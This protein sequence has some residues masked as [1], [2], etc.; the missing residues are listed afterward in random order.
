[1]RFS[2]FEQSKSGNAASSFRLGKEKKPITSRRSPEK[3]LKK[4]FPANKLTDIGE[5]HTLVGGWTTPR[6]VTTISN[7]NDEIV[8]ILKE[9]RDLQKE[10]VA[11][12]KEAL[13][14]NKK[15]FEFAKIQQEFVKTQ[16]KLFLKKA[17][18]AIVIFLGLALLL[19]F[20]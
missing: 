15:I 9:I 7:M 20:R 16:Q 10:T 12:Q 8:H 19:I 14:S 3:L 17:S 4:V 6:E 18:V 13:E 2:E 11:N 1:M 5:I